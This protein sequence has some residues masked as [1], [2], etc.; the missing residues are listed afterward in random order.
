MGRHEPPR[1]EDE[2]ILDNRRN[3]IHEVASIL[4]I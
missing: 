3:A 1:N 4:G 2:N